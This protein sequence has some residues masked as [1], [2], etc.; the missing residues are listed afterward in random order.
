MTQSAVPDEAHHAA[1]WPAQSPPP[2]GG[3]KL[4]VDKTI[5]IANILTM[6]AIAFSVVTY[7]MKTYQEVFAAI[8][9]SQHD[10]ASISERVARA[11]T[12]VNQIRIDSVAS[13]TQLR[14]EIQQDLREMRSTLNNISMSL[15][16]LPPH[17]SK[18]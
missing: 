9:K 12:A 2:T 17:L 7:G 11:E 4:R 10:I 14:Q 15:S 5:N 16:N 3:G 8:T 18:R 1:P 13:S 6:C